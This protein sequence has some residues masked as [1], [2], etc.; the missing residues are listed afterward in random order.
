MTNGAQSA[1]PVAATAALSSSGSLASAETAHEPEDDDMIK[2]ESDGDESEVDQ[3][4]SSFG[5]MKVD[6]NKSMYVGESHWAAILSDIAEVKNYFAEHRKQLEDQYEKVAASTGG[7]GTKGPVFLYGTVPPPAREELIAAIPPRLTVD[8]LVARYFNSYDP[9]VHIIHAPTFQK[10]YETHFANPS[11]TPVIWIGL[12]FA[13]MCLAMQ[14]YHRAG[15]EPPEYQ[16]RTMHMAN[17]NRK[18]TAECIVAAD[19]SKPASTVLETL[20]LNLQADVYRTREA[21]VGNWIA[22]GMIVRLAMRMGYHRDP[23]PYP[24]ISPF[25]GEMRRRVWTFIHMLDLLLSFQMGLP[26]MIRSVDCDTK[27]P[28]NIYDDEFGESTTVLPPSRPIT[29]ATPVS[30]MITKARFAVT[31]GQIV[32][33]TNSLGH[34]AYEDVMRLDN[35]LRETRA[36]IPPHLRLRPLE[37][38]VVDPANLIMQRF[39][40]DLLYHKGLCVLHR[41][42]LTRAA[43]NPRYGH[44]RRACVDG[45]MELLRHQATLHY[46]SRPNGRLRSVKWFISSL[47][48]Q[49]FLLAAMIICLDLN[50]S[51]EADTTSSDPRNL[52]SWGYERQAEMVQALEQ[53]KAIWSELRDQSMEAYKASELLTVMLEKVKRAYPESGAG[54]GNPNIS[55]SMPYSAGPRGTDDNAS[56]SFNNDETK[57]EHSAAMTLGM[58]SSGGVIPSAA[59][60]FDKTFGSLPPEGDQNPNIAMTEASGLTPNFAA[61]SGVGDVGN[62]GGSPFSLFGNATS[63]TDLPSHLDWDAWD[64]FVQGTTLDAANQPWPTSTDPSTT[65]SPGGGGVVISEAQQHGRTYP[66]GGGVFMGVSTP[67][68]ST[69]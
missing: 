49:D 41:K 67:P 38:A 13:I 66:G 54:V 26:S 55:A 29:E 52:Y 61:E 37:E 5:V 45:S 20:I 59:T 30:Y 63:M 36:Q 8:K 51:T 43:M 24:G 1:G 22:A 4:T 31:F 27:L 56:S 7:I 47:T 33:Q 62:A 18:R 6:A 19:F 9:A 17:L 25:R 14:S 69:M 53:S 64:S 16:G 23:S 65:A 68:N 42:F 39:N 44:S 15:E 32:E 46:E 60:T 21:D 10:E 57:P 12:L 34:R 11:K 40:L 58:L 2:E 48:A 35:K 50:H 3:V 28:R